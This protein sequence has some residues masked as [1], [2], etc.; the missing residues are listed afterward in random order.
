[1]KITKFDHSCFYIEKE[2]RG[3]VF[4]P[5]EYDAKLPKIVNLDCIIV[6][7]KHGD[8]FQ[9]E[10][11]ARLVVDNPGVKIFTTGDNAEAI[12]GS[13]VAK[14]G[15]VEN[16][17]V[18]QLAFFGG[19]HAPIYKDEVPC[20]NIGT[21]VDGVVVNPADSFDFPD[22]ATSKVLFAPISAPWLKLGETMEY[23]EAHR[24]GVVMNAH[25]ALLSELGIAVANN[26]A[27]QKSEDVGASYK[28]LRAGES[29]EV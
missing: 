22:G 2:G 3:L 8:H 24:P 17:G 10:V 19:N 21:V 11:L 23:I 20:E 6:T 27:G 13:Q 29:I 5:V 14:S 15:E 28:F 26:W 16:V 12:A 4:D 1:M 18:F 7:H 9:P 25:N